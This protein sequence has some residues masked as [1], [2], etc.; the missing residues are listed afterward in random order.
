MKTIN[1]S[2][3]IYNDTAKNFIKFVETIFEDAEFNS[4]N[5]KYLEESKPYLLS[6][7][8]SISILRGQM[9]SDPKLRPAN[10]DLVFISKKES[11]FMGRY[12]KLFNLVQNQ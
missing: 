9:F 8:Y 3:E 10:Y 12:D 5:L 7:V 6:L 4:S 1:N 2:A 11:E